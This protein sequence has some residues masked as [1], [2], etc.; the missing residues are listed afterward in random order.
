MLKPSGTCKIRGLRHCS[1][2]NRKSRQNSPF[3]RSGYRALSSMQKPQHAANQSVR[4]HCLQG[5][6]PLQR[7]PRALRLLQ[8][9]EVNS[10]FFHFFLGAGIP[11]FANSPRLPKGWPSWFAGAPKVASAPSGPGFGTLRAILLNPARRAPP[12]EIPQSIPI[13]VVLLYHIVIPTHII[14]LLCF[15]FFRFYR[16]GAE[17]RLAFFPLYLC[18]S[19][20]QALQASKPRSE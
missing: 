4:Q 2:S 13:N 7:L 9:L 11:A 16:H 18:F 10:F 19:C 17:M 14:D 8:V 15:G 12:H 5:A 20:L 6:V 3:F 1:A